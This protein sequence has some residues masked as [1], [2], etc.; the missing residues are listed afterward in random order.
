M[1]S[2]SALG[3]VDIQNIKN[4]PYLKDK[5]K[6]SCDSAF[7]T[8]ELR[9]CANMNFQKS[10]SILNMIYEAVLQKCEELQLPN[11][12]DTIKQ[13]NLDWIKYRD[14]HCKVYWTMYE[15]GTFQSIVFLN[16][17]TKITD[18]RREELEVLLMELEQ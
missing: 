7:T 15:G 9:I 3:Q 8:L 16:C 10:D 13:A 5:D 1:A 2:L 6:V 4:Q 12:G 11:V 14:R 17:L 18:E